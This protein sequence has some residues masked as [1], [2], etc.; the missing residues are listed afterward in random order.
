MLFATGYTPRYRGR[1]SDLHRPAALLV[2]DRELRPD[3]R[4]CGARLL[5]ACR[6]AGIAAIS[7]CAGI[8][9]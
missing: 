1:G 5:A 4:A 7:L 2:V 9:K 3:L 8:V 6:I